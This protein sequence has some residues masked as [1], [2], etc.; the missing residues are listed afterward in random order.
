MITRYP[1]QRLFE[2]IIDGVRKC[3]KG[4]IDAAVPAVQKDLTSGPF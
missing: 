1:C 2:K 3:F 4:V